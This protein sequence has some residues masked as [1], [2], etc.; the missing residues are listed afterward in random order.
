MNN[1]HKNLT[2]AIKDN[3]LIY[4]NDVEKGLSCGCICPAC[5]EKLIAKKGS[6][7][8][9]HFAHYSTDCGK[10]YE[11]SLHIL[12]K[13]ILSEAG[14]IMLPSVNIIH[15]C[16]NM[17][18]CNA[19]K[20]K[21][22][23]VELE[24]ITDDIIPDIIVHSSNRRLFIEIRVTHKVDNTKLEKIKNIGISAIEIDL[25]KYNK[26]ISKLEL[27]NILID[28]N[29]NKS[30]IYNTIAEKYFR[31]LCF[32]SEEK[33]VIRRGFAFHVDYCPIKAREWHGKPYAN[34]IDDCTSCEYL[35]KVNSRTIVNNYNEFDEETSIICA[36]KN[37]ISKK[38][39]LIKA[40]NKKKL[41]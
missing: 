10:G 23:Y 27:K 32:F 2:Y 37:K 17:L 3:K 33:A 40:I 6:K 9:Y 30:W 4:I 1:E 39:N 24:K 11:T 20:I 15:S 31:A 18:I 34:F 28:S 36:G 21:I 25:S 12:A 7:I 5:G 8:L 16:S 22:D 19:S 26:D 35:V 38:E 13:E 14:E 29:N 41:T